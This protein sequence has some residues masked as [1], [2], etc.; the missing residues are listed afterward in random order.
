MV[1]V[2]MGEKACITR[3][4]QRRK[5]VVHARH[6]GPRVV[7]M[8]V[9]G[10]VPPSPQ[11]RLTLFGKQAEMVL[12]HAVGDLAG[13]D[14]TALRLQ[15]VQHLRLRHAQLNVERQHKGVQ[16]AAKGLPPQGFR[17]G[18]FIPLA[19]TFGGETFPSI[20]HGVRLEEKV[21]PHDSPIAPVFDIC[22]QAA[23]IQAHHWLTVDLEALVPGRRTT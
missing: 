21:L 3:V 16:L 1:L 14:D 17:P 4:A 23:A 22:R 10:G 13:G 18:G 20:A 11:H 19:R 12:H 5:V 7:N 2:P 6:A 9:S 8:L 15:E